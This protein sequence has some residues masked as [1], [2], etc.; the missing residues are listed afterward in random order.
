MLTALSGAQP[1][2]PEETLKLQIEFVCYTLHA[3]CHH[4]MK[5]L[6]HTQ[7]SYQYG[8]SYFNWPF[9]SINPVC[10]FLA[11]EFVL[12]EDS[13]K[14]HQLISSNSPCLNVVLLKHLTS[15]NHVKVEEQ[16]HISKYIF[17]C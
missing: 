6:G 8:D 17:Q 14:I 13:K 3:D 11:K 7:W 5:A 4:I 10:E 2:G 1:F 16:T 12:S 15:N 9:A